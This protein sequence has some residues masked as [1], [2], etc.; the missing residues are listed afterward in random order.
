[1]RISESYRDIRKY[2][3]CVLRFEKCSM[4]ASNNASSDEPFSEKIYRAEK[5]MRRKTL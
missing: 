2:K 1:M 3:L 4:N 5:P